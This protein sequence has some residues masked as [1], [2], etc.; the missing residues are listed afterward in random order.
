MNETSAL[1][2]LHLIQLAGGQGTRAAATGQEIPKQFRNICG[3]LLFQFSLEAFLRLP[4]EAVT[5]VSVTMNYRM[6]L[7]STSGRS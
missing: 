5:I 4:K 6:D 2:R 3:K 7:F 1:P